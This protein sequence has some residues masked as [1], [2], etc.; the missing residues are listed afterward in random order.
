MDGRGKRNDFY[1]C[2]LQLI[3]ET[4]SL[5]VG[6]TVVFITPPLL[7]LIPIKVCYRTC[8]V[9]INRFLTSVSPSVNVAEGWEPN[10]DRTD[11]VDP[12]PNLPLLT[13]SILNFTLSQDES[14]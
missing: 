4:I 1:R 7:S 14:E 5:C 11:Y 13:P 8:L 10:Q 3:Y 9:N 6:R 12:T 2:L